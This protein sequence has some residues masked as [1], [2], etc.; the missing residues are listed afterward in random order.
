MATTPV[1][2]VGRSDTERLR[3]E[4]LCAYPATSCG[5]PFAK[6]FVMGFRNMKRQVD[7]SVFKYLPALLMIP[8]YFRM[9][10]SQFPRAL[11]FSF[12]S[13]HPQCSVH[14]DLRSFGSLRLCFLFCKIS[15][16]SMESIQP[17][18]PISCSHFSS[19]SEPPIHSLLGNDQRD[20]VPF[21]A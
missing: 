3:G 8:T 13:W 18:I 6:I 17:L 14:T 5:R 16:S 20:P 4:K 1:Q 12:S 7:K 15:F 9:P 21:K 2:I 10:F 19:K 11:S